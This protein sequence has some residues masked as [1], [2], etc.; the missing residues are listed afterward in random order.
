MKTIPTTE[1]LEANSLI[2]RI[3]LLESAFRACPVTDEMRRYLIQMDL[4]T[5]YKM[6]MQTRGPTLTLILL[7]HAS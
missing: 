3:T 4:S 7:S 6:L 5:S 1:I 2:L